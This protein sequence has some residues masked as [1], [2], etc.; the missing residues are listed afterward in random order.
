MSEAG[1]QNHSDEIGR[2][3]LQQDST[4]A[5]LANHAVLQLPTFTFLMP[6]ICG[7]ELNF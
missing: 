7:Q 4:N 3:T 1:I 5:D 2:V 6:V